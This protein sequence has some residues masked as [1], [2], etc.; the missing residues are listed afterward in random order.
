MNTT[1]EEVKALLAATCPDWEVTYEA[2]R[3][4]NVKAT[5]KNPDARFIYIEEFTSGKYMRPV[6]RPGRT[7]MTRVQI[8]FC[9]FKLETNLNTRDR[10]NTA[11][12][13]ELVR[14]MIET[15]AVLP[16]LDG[17]Y[18]SPKFT[19]KPTEVPFAT[20]LPRFADQE[21]S[22]MI[23]LDVQLIGNC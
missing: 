6:G 10:V 16:F 13:R 3:L 1:R 19:N 12:Q 17:F 21:V 15:A 9:S 20:P 22:V 4:M 2:S 11:E 8:W 18:A 5:E 14:E 7:R 23:E